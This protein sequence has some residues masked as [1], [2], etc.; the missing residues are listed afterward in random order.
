VAD[1]IIGQAQ[2]GTHVQVAGEPVNGFTPIQAWVSSD[3]LR[4]VPPTPAGDK[5]L[6]PA[7]PHPPTR[8]TVIA[9]ALSAAAEVGIPPELLCACGLAESGLQWNARRPKDPADDARYWKRK[10]ISFGA[11]QQTVYWSQDWVAAGLGSLFRPEKIEEIGRRYYD[12]VYAAKV[13]AGQLNH[14]YKEYGDVVEALYRYNSPSGRCPT[15][16][17]ANYRRALHEARAL[18]GIQP[19]AM[20]LPV[21]GQRQQPWAPLVLGYNPPGSQW[22][23]DLWGCFL[24]CVCSLAGQPP[25]VM[26]ERLKAAGLFKPGSGEMATHDFSLVTPFRLV[27]ELPWSE[28]LVSADWMERLHEHLAR[29]YPAIACVNMNVALKRRGRKW[30]YVL[31]REVQNGHISGW[32]PWYA[33]AFSLADRYAQGVKSGQDPDAVAVYQFML[34][35]PSPTK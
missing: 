13:A 18:L 29:G 35:A 32:D 33:D 23:I 7:D 2:P 1:N 9:A 25:D 8:E 16:N 34:Y 22:T 15:E 31:L 26:N 3:L 21:Y 27:G 24:A 19:L 17:R 30:H 10:D 14:W 20:T 28:G 5:A 12:P 4:P 6:A 11:W